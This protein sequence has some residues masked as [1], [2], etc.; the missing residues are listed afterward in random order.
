MEFSKPLTDIEVRETQKIFLECS[1]SKPDL[2]ATWYK[3]GVKVSASETVQLFSEGVLHSLCI[4]RSQLSDEAEYSI[5]IDGE[6]SKAK[7]KVIGKL[8]V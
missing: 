6:S 2:P 3:K 8:F 7:V 4:P 5:K 1:V